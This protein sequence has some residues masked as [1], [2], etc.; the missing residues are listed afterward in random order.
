ML[1]HTYFI[2]LLLA[3]IVY[4][5]EDSTGDTQ[6]IHDGNNQGYD[7]NVVTEW[8]KSNSSYYDEEENAQ[9][10]NSC[11]RTCV[12]PCPDAQT[13]N[14]DQVKCGEIDHPD[15]VWPDCTKDEI[16]IPKDCE[17]KSQFFCLFIPQ[18]IGYYYYI[19]IFYLIIIY[20]ISKTY[21]YIKV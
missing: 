12:E 15:D 7:A 20:I 6:I 10:V 8:D 16:C 4:A 19:I 1:R 13:C 18:H 17:C 14:E 9:C 11:K 21:I 3:T 5:Q 2:V